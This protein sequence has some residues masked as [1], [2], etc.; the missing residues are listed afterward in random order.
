VKPDYKD[1]PV[2]SYD[3]FLEAPE[4]MGCMMAGHSH[5]YIDS[6]GNVEPCVFL[7]VTFGNILQEDFSI[8]LDRMRI[9]IPRPLHAV[10]PSVQLCQTIKNK[11]DNGVPMPVPYQA[12]KAELHALI[13]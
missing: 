2:I 3:A 8:I 6:F 7:P 1:Y 13:P 12:I 10:C 9:A 4:N 5:L 11:K